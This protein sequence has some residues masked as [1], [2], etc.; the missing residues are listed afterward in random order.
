MVLGESAREAIPYVVQYS[1]ADKSGDGAALRASEPPSHDWLDAQH[2]GGEHEI[3]PGGVRHLSKGQEFVDPPN[4][5]G[6]AASGNSTY[7]TLC[8]ACT[9][10]TN[11]PVWFWTGSA[12]AENYASSLVSESPVVKLIQHYQRLITDHYKG[13]LQSCVLIGAAK[14]RFPSDV[15]EIVQ[16]HAELPTPVAR[17]RKDEVE[18][19]YGYSI[20]RSLARS[21]L[22]PVMNWSGT[23]SRT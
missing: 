3:E 8:E 2:R 18:P 15:L 5:Q 4:A 16:I 12:N 10:A 22:P 14:G 7:R 20:R 19:I 9:C 1:L 13:M 11:T 21:T 23:K 6:F 17:N